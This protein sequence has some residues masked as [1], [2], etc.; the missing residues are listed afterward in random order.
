MF[1]FSVYIF[2]SREFPRIEVL[3]VISRILGWVESCSLDKDNL[4]ISF[5][6]TKKNDISGMTAYLVIQEQGCKII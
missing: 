1:L 2:T 3:G 4:F 6:T 5:H